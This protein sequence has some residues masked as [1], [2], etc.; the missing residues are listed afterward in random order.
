MTSLHIPAV[1]GRYELHQLVIDAPAT[2]LWRAEM[3]CAAGLRRPVAFKRLQ[4]QLAKERGSREAFAR[5]AAALLQLDHPNVA[6]LV[7]FGEDDAGYF[8]ATEW[9]WGLTLHDIEQLCAAHDRRPSPVVLA[10]MGIEVLRAFETA[11]RR[12]MRSP[13]G[14]AVPAP[15]LQRDLSPGAVLLTVRGTVK[16]TD[17]GLPRPFTLAALELLGADD[18]RVS[19]LAPELAGGG[20]PSVASDLYACAVMLWEAMVGRRL[21]AGVNVPSV[22]ALLR[23]G[24]RPPRVR[25]LRPDVHPELAQVIDRA[26]A[27]SPAD[28]F[29]SATAFA[30]ALGDA[31]R[32]IPER[33]DAARLSW[34]V[35]SALQIRQRMIESWRPPVPSMPVIDYEEE[36][37]RQFIAPLPGVSVD[38]RQSLVPVEMDEVG[39]SPPP[40]TLVPDE[41]RAGRRDSAETVILS[42]TDLAAFDEDIVKGRSDVPA[43]SK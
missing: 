4:P 31:L 20:R 13:N 8:L 32:G 40:A 15:L 7:E 23:N 28:R 14:G 26:M 17:F 38:T 33:T 39:S 12:V 22:F 43:A 27:P 18:P 16:V 35:T 3:R 6:Q 2:Q 9:A 34:E 24:H 41:P 30:R 1:G 42:T 5:E 37:T 36:S 29:E 21:W 25:E 10:A 19:Y 11:H